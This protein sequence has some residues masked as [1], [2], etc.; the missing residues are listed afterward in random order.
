[1]AV[2][3]LN[4]HIIN[5]KNSQ[6]FKSRLLMSNLKMKSER[7]K[8]IMKE[9]MERKKIIKGVWELHYTWLKRINK[10]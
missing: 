9:N 1:M 8:V 6:L 7:K 4:I 2:F 5:K 10:F 3:G